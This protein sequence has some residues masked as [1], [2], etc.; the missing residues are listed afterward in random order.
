MPIRSGSKA[1]LD[2]LV[3]AHE[4]VVFDDPQLSM[5]ETGEEFREFR[6]SS[7]FLPQKRMGVMGEE[8]ERLM[9]A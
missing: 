2:W 5:S 6:I 7:S 1:T 8:K 9:L 3:L 4:S